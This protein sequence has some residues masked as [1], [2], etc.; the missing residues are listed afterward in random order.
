MG[1]TWSREVSEAV[2]SKEET[3]SGKRDSNLR[4]SAWGIARGGPE[5]A[6]VR[7]EFERKRNERVEAQSDVPHCATLVQRYR[8]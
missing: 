1:R 7:E 6:Q 5:T 3:W 8:D 4:P 2:G